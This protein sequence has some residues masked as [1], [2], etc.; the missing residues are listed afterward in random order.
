M[1]GDVIPPTPP[2]AFPDGDIA[3]RGRL[4][5]LGRPIQSRRTIPVAPGPLF[6][7]LADLENHW[8]L[9][10]FVRVVRLDGEPGRHDG[11]ILRIRGPLG[12]RRTAHAE[13][14]RVTFE[15]TIEGTA[16]VG[17][18]TLARVVWRL[19]P[20]PGGTAVE[21]TATVV[22][23]GPLDRLL[24]RFGGRWWLTRGFGAVLRGLAAKVADGP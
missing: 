15:R 13:I 16:T 4:R 11:S 6:A 8:R 2:G 1:P 5:G 14:D 17:P 10:A 18:R 22:R 21:L 3:P 12:V 19:D 9:A 7:F 23:A 20:Q 24:L